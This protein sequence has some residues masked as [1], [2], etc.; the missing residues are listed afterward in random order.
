MQIV[1][2]V[3]LKVTLLQIN[4]VEKKFIT[5]LGKNEDKST[6]HLL[7]PYVTR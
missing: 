1:I 4:F 2:L 3:T 6:A 5:L 7:K